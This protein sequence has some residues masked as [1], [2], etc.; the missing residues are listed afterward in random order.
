MILFKMLMMV[1]WKVLHRS[2]VWQNIKSSTSLLKICL[3]INLYFWRLSKEM[4]TWSVKFC[5][6]LPSECPPSFLQMVAHPPAPG[7]Q[8]ALH[9]SKNDIL[10]QPGSIQTLWHVSLL[11]R[12]LTSLSSHQE[13]CFA[14]QRGEH[15][16]SRCTFS[17]RQPGETHLQ[18]K[19]VQ[20]KGD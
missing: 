14:Y 10:N 13:V 8:M 18:L 12:L 6:P 11:Q 17:A 9:N 4:D 1:H 15:H 20:N 2:D 5:Q 19:T 3:H 7:K 16:L